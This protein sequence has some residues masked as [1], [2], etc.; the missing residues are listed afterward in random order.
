MIELSTMRERLAQRSV[1]NEIAGPAR[2]G[3]EMT[4][5]CP[6][7]SRRQRAVEDIFHRRADIS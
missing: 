3:E 7:A 2:A 1:G 4:S 6:C 5:A